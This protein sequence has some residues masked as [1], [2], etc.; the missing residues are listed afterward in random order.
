VVSRRSWQGLAQLALGAFHVHAHAAE[1]RAH[2]GSWSEV[3]GPI[4]IWTCP[5]T[6]GIAYGRS[7]LGYPHFHIKSVSMEDSYSATSLVSRTRF[8][9]QLRWSL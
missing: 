3:E 4:Q 8:Y 6:Y 9:H 5:S 7:V 2:E 1:H